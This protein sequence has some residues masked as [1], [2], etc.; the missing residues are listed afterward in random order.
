MRHFRPADKGQMELYLRWHQK[1]E[2]LE[3]ELPP[4]GLILCA[5]ADG[6]HVELLLLVKRKKV[7]SYNFIVL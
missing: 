3:G 4:I 6:E 2:Q 7:V 1:Y 5:D